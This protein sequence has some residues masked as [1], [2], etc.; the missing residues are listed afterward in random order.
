MEQDCL[1]VGEGA[2]AQNNGAAFGQQHG[3][4]CAGKPAMYH[5]S[6]S[7][8][9]Q[10]ARHRDLRMRLLSG[11]FAGLQDIFNNRLYK[12]EVLAMV[13]NYPSRLY[14]HFHFPTP[15]HTTRHPRPKRIA[16]SQG[17]LLCVLNNDGDGAFIIRNIDVATFDPSPRVDVSD[18]HYSS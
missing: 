1:I 10:L 15:S 9:F 17:R 16:S 11:H 12:E 7:S 2:A 3:V 14:R 13:H 6:N 18:E 4:L 8:A 5:H